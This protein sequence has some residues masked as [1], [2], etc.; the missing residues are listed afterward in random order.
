MGTSPT[1]P[2]FFHPKLDLSVV[3]AGDADDVGAKPAKELGD[4]RSDVTRI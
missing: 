1:F 3:S 4:G 2:D